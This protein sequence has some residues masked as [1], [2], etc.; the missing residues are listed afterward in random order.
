MPNLSIFSKKKKKDDGLTSP[1]SPVR[2]S[3]PL[4]PTATARTSGSFHLH[5]TKTSESALSANNT[6]ATATK[7]PP[8][9]P[10]KPADAI[11]TASPSPPPQ[12]QPSI[13]NLIH[14]SN[15]PD[16]PAKVD[17]QTQPLNQTRVTKG[18]YSA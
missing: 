13:Q 1:T 7:P 9:A 14:P 6:T 15:T 10:P 4:T 12:M 5:K 18:K 8:A 17:F 11:S 2:D 3:S 16:A